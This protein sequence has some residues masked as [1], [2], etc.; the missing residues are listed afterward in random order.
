[1]Y[2][3]KLSI[4]GKLS[5]ELSYVFIDDEVEQL[6][7]S[8]TL[9]GMFDIKSGS[10][11][12]HIIIKEAV[13]HFLDFYHRS[14]SSGGSDFGELDD[15]GEF[16]FESSIQYTYEKV[17][18]ALRD[19]QEQGARGSQIEMR[20]VNCVLGAIIDNTLFLST[21]G[22]SLSPFLIYPITTTERSSRYSMVNIIKQSGETPSDTTSRLF[23]NI[24]SGKISIPLS[25]LILCN[26]TLLDYIDP[27]HIKQIV[28][29]TPISSVITNFHTILS[30]VNSRAD[31]SALLFSN[32]PSNEQQYSKTRSTLSS[33]SM[34]GLNGT[35]ERTHSILTPAVHP[36]LKKYSNQFLRSVWLLL[37]AIV[38]FCIQWFK[39]LL[40][41]ERLTQYRKILSALWTRSSS[42]IAHAPT[43]AHRGTRSLQSGVSLLRSTNW[44][45]VHSRFALILQEKIAALLDLIHS[46]KIRFSNLSQQSRSLLLLSSLFILLFIVS[47]ISMQVHKSAQQAGTRTREIIAGLEQKIDQIDASMLY[48]DRDRARSLLNESKALLALVPP[49]YHSRS[50]YKDIEEKI[51]KS[52]ARIN[53]IIRI[54]SLD[55]LATLGPDGSG[56]PP[57][58]RSIAFG[59]SFIAYSTDTLYLFDQ[60]T[61]QFEPLTDIREKITTISCAI[62]VSEKLFYFC[63][64]DGSKLTSLTLPDRKVTSTSLPRNAGET[65]L[66]TIRLYNN[67][68]YVLTKSSG[69]IYRHL[70]VTTGFSRGAPWTRESQEILKGA[71]SFAIDGKVYVLGPDGSVH[72]YGAGLLQNRLT[73]ET[74]R[75][76]LVHAT[77]LWTDNDDPLLY[78]LVPSEKKIVAIHKETFDLAAQ[79]TSDQFTNLQG[80][81]VNRTR[82]EILVLD[83]GRLIRVP[84]ELK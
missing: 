60:R 33:T 57:N 37:N 19:A 24:I 9:F 13:K 45:T 56:S 82:K 61:R 12:Y 50:D 64:G 20:K 73:S 31:F 11:L 80:F 38:R 78:A 81:A 44:S 71:K 55:V 69:T 66:D 29:N 77:D 6:N 17:S 79:I 43:I 39:S 22:T 14:S 74:A 32:S 58:A 15:S 72:L 59:S 25:T 51:M 67:R 7:C 41:P 62:A 65:S 49:K 2:S 3:G 34:Q 40:S 21:T 1:M 27:Q 4:P 54:D 46:T 52:D 70:S 53:N 16:L 68:L 8:T 18:D 30:K 26:Q 28:S 36:Y 5:N 10:E 42:V 63:S 35:E 23:A 76:L 48:D 75:T 47:L 83:A 84:F